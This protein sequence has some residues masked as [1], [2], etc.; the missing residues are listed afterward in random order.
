MKN[1][2]VLCA[3]KSKFS[4]SLS[5]V[6]V[7]GKPVIGWILDDVLRKQIDEVVI[8][9]RPDDQRL[10]KFVNWAYGQRLTV[11][12]VFPTGS[13][14]LHSLQAGLQAC[15][16]DSFLRVI[17]GD[18]LIRDDFTGSCDFV[19]IGA[20]E[21]A[22]RWC[23]IT[24]DQNGFVRDYVDKPGDYVPKQ[25]ALAGYYHFLSGEKL[26]ACLNEALQ[27]EQFELS[28]VLQRYGKFR[29]IPVQEWY[30]FGHIDNLV[31][32]RRRL[33]QPRYFNTL[34][35]H[36]T[37]NT[38]TKISENNQKLK[39]ELDWYLSLPDALKVLTPRI[40]RQDNLDGHVRIVQEYYGYPTLAELYVYGDLD[41][42]IWESI[43]RQVLRVQHEFACYRGELTETEIKDIYLVKTQE[44][45]QG[46]SQDPDWKAL[47]E[48][49]VIQF[50]GRYLK[51]VNELLKLLEPTILELAASAPVGIIH[52]DFCFSNILF[53]VN[54]Q[55]IRLIDPRGRFGRK[56]IYGDLRYDLAKLR[57]SIAGM[58]DYIVAG[59]FSLD[60][61]EG[62]IFFGHVFFNGVQENLKR[63]FDFLLRQNGYSIREIQLIEGLLFISMLPYH[64]DHPAR[65]K[66]FYL[67]GLR[68]LNEVLD[69]NCD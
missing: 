4:D 64:Q 66:M 61:K 20:V 28:N 40:F 22:R 1:T 18:T 62:R 55:I 58:Y 23:L 51:N 54:N 42:E 59:M 14:I 49:P 10:M 33:L 29:A 35:I 34:S 9:V 57:H 37:I 48:S 19:Y 32:A 68:L 15:Q 11:Y 21:D 52:G 27:H 53:D 7:N 44:R 13:T 45:L 63:Y 26:Y 31:E 43:L 46:L 60:E 2:I 38:I 3:G 47:L 56:G 69:E 17:L 36:P 30:D 12:F 50:N 41:I 67:T 24:T 39:D 6:P 65:Q 25:M 16:T 5:M 8:V